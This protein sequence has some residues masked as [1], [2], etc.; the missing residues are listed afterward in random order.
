M[1]RLTAIWTT[2]ALIGL[3][4]IGCE[5]NAGPTASD[6]A[7]D[8]FGQALTPGSAPEVASASLYLYIASPSM[9]TVNVHRASVD[10]SDAVTWNSFGGAFAP[11]VYASF[12]ANMPGWKAVDV[13]SLVQAW[14][15]GNQP[16]YGF[17]LDQPVA[18]Y[19]RAV[20]FSSDGIMSHPYLEVC[21]ATAAGDSCVQYAPGR[22]TYI[23]QSVPD[24]AFGSAEV[25]QTGYADAYGNENQALLWFDVPVVAD[26]PP[27]DDTTGVIDPVQD[28]TVAVENCTRHSLFWVRN[29]GCGRWSDGDA[30]SALLPLWLGSEGGEHSIEITDNCKALHYL[31]GPKMHGWIRPLRPLY[32]ELLTA[33]LNIAAGADPSAVAAVIEAADAFVA[34]HADDMRSFLDRENI[35]ELKGWWRTLHRYNQ[36]EI[37]PGACEV[38]PSPGFVLGE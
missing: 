25:L 1:R 5:M 14:R 29:S 10:W 23:D 22:D 32:I 18:V 3:A 27:A 15:A 21:Y 19:P 6:S 12:A 13:S 9:Q 30:I 20:Y 24:N 34:S 28:T 38:E 11:D 16:N 37:G 36:G 7:E 26:P 2:F 31:F 35:D 4:V 8:I 33:K 17:L